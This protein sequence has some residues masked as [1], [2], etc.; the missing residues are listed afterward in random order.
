MT[1]IFFLKRVDFIIDSGQMALGLE[2]GAGKVELE[3]NVKQ[4][5]RF[6]V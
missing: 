5:I 1:M 2:K 3:V 4:K 6:S